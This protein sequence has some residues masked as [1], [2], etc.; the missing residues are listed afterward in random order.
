MVW[1]S[2]LERNCSYPSWY[3]HYPKKSKKGAIKLFKESKRDNCSFSREVNSWRYRG[4]RLSTFIFMKPR[5]CRAI[6]LQKVDPIGFFNSCQNIGIGI[7]TCKNVLVCLESCVGMSRQHSTATTANIM[8]LCDNN[9]KD[10]CQ[11]CGKGLFKSSKLQLSDR[12]WKLLSFCQEKS[13]RRATARCTSI[14][15]LT[16]KYV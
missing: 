3:R 14:V 8:D 16:K 9:D 7:C 5:R 2:F 12:R 13:R 15:P 4:T 6:L 11:F 1:T 10:K